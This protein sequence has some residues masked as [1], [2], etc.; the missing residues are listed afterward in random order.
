MK[1]YGLSQRLGKRLDIRM[2]CCLANFQFG[3]EFCGLGSW[4]PS[5]PLTQPKL[6]LNSFFN[7]QAFKNR[8]EYCGPLASTELF[9]VKNDLFWLTPNVG[10]QQCELAM[11]RYVGICGGSRND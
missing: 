3:T 2:G 11:A 6:Y 8:H 7:W 1:R 4:D 9:V 10:S 5:L